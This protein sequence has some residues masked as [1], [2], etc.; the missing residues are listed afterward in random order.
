MIA[1]F[2][3]K[4][5][6]NH[7]FL[8]YSAWD[9]QKIAGEELLMPAVFASEASGQCFPDRYLSREETVYGKV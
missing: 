9:A 3:K 5:R 4:M 7:L 6:L 8:E 2:S 1:L